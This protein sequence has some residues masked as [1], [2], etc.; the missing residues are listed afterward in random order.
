MTDVPVNNPSLWD[1]YGKA[2]LSALLAIYTVVVPFWTGDHH[3]DA[4]EGILIA[5]A[6]ANALMVYLVPLTASFPGIKSVINFV[7]AG[8]LVAQTVITDGI[9][10]NE[11][12][13]I[14]GAALAAIGVSVA[15]AASP[16][17]RVKVLAGS[18]R[19]KRF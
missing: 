8:L 9:D 4:S 14:I 17:E 16:Q 10:A 15:P 7:M 18:D 11:W 12:L 6:I 5:L 13:L 2:I 1:K 3:I 19:A